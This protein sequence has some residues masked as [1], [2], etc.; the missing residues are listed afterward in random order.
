M[1]LLRKLSHFLFIVVSQDTVEAKFKNGIRHMYWEKFLTSISGIIIHPDFFSG[2][3][4]R[5]M[6]KSKE[7][8]EK[9]YSFKFKYV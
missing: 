4:N 5:G 7:G 8:L 1:K 2:F 9:V 6:G 3:K